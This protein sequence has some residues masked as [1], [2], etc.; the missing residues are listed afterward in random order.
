MET[1]SILNV[2]SWLHCDS[3]M[4]DRFNTYGRASNELL[5]LGFNLKYKESC[6]RL[7]KEMVLLNYEAVND[8]YNENN[9]PQEFKCNFNR[10]NSI[11]QILK[12]LK[13]WLYQCA[14]GDIPETS[15]L[16]KTMAL[17]QYLICEV[18]ATGTNEYENADWD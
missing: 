8:R 4:P 1:K 5:K 14:E 10:S 17:V 18:I 3:V 6:E 2:V 12:S 13:C 16:Y 9:N 7:A 11:Y 15:N